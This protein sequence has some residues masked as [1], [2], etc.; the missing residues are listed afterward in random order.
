MRLRRARRSADA[1]V[2]GCATGVRPSV[3]AVPDG[4]P[5]ALAPGTPECQS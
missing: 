5:R 1:V 3:V 2:C 4:P